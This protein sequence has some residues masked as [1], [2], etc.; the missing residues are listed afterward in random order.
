MREIPGTEF[1]KKIDLVFIAMGFIHVEHDRLVK[2]IG[3]ELDNRGN[4]KTD[5][6]YKTSVDG[7]FA[8]GDAAAG[9]SLVVRAFAHGRDAAIAISDYLS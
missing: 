9:A 5:G 8:A 7:V 3:V 1:S 2:S 6:C 4:I